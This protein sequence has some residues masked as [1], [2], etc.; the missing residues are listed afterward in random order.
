MYCYIIADTTDAIVMPQTSRKSCWQ[1]RHKWMICR[2][3]SVM[4]STRGNTGKTST[5]Y[6]ILVQLSLDTCN[7]VQINK[8]HSAENHFKLLLLNCLYLNNYLYNFVPVLSWCCV[9]RLSPFMKKNSKLCMS[10]YRHWTGRGHLIWPLG[11]L[12]YPILTREFLNLRKR[13][14]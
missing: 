5:T 7:I 6:V 13:N 3:A 11:Q 9:N 4:L 12:A 1:Q 10:F 14:R 8:T 2:H